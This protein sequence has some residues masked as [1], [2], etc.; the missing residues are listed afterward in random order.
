MDRWDQASRS[1][2]VVLIGI[3]DNTEEI[4]ETFCK[5][6]S[7]NYSISYYLLKKI[8]E[9]CPIILKKNLSLKK[10]EALA[11]TLRSFGALI[12]VEEKI[13]SPPISLEFQEISPPSMSL[14]SSSLRRTQGGVWNLIGRAKNISER[15]LNDTWVLVQLFN[16]FEEILTFEEVPLPINPLPSGEVSPFKVV[17]EGDLPISKIS[18]AFKN[19]SGSPIP[20]F[21]RRKKREWV[22]VESQGENE[23]KSSSIES[24]EPSVRKLIESDSGIQIEISK[25]SKP[26]APS[27]LVKERLEKEEIREEPSEKT[28]WLNHKK[29]SGEITLEPEK[30][31]LDLSMKIF[32]EEENRIGERLEEPIEIEFPQTAPQP[33]EEEEKEKEILVP[34]FEFHLEEE[35]EKLERPPAKASMEKGSLELLEEVSRTT[36]EEKEHLA[37]FPW[38]ENFRNAV[39]N[40]YQRSQN[41]FFI[42]FEENRKKDG[43]IDAYH[44]LLTILLHARFDQMDQPEKASVNTQKVFRLIVRSNLLLDEIPSIE[45]TKYVSG[46]N[47]RDLLYRAIPKLQQVANDILKKSRWDALEL[48]RLIQVI[49]HM[50][51][52]NSRKAVRWMHTLIPNVIEIYLSEIPVSI[53]ESLYRVASRLGVVDP[54]FDHYQGRHSMGDI[55]IQSFAQEAFPRDPMKIEEPMNWIGRSRDGGYCFPTEPRCEGCLFEAFC[56]KLYV[57]FNP[58]EKGMRG[59]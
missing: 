35:E 34:E 29:A 6:L 32:E 40:Y 52:Q 47:W 2:R 45:G 59:Q 30:N 46:E 23:E 15:G 9:R 31:S 44:S 27:L 28:S 5:T 3:G 42:W 25:P 39:E 12:S 10:A 51:D 16:D 58:S 38:I 53:G 19:S 56:P 14:E 57:Q 20:T 22:E 1:F 18:I 26:E 50:S 21:D 41:I 7:E 36:K 33:V 54:H 13:D 8:V 43:F 49:P 11:K 55:K 37:L 48:E 4:K 24:P 17:F